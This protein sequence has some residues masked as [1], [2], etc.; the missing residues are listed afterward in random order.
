MVEAQRPQDKDI[1]IKAIQ[2]LEDLRTQGGQRSRVLVSS[3]LPDPV[4]RLQLVIRTKS[5]T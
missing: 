1:H 5:G 3:R 4:L 2:L